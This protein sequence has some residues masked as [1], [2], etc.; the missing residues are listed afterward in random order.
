MATASRSSQP[1]RSSA[2]T[3]VPPPDWSFRGWRT[4]LPGCA[5]PSRVTVARGTDITCSAGFFLKWRP[6]RRVRDLA[7]DGDRKTT[8]FGFVPSADVGGAARSVAQERTLSAKSGGGPTAHRGSHLA[9]ARGSSMR[10][11]RTEALIVSLRPRPKLVA[12][13]PARW[14]LTLANAGGGPADLPQLAAGRRSRSSGPASRA[15][16]GATGECSCR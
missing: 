16:A 4:N 10:R 3:L 1:G 13:G 8:R 2:S 15:T 11:V 6:Y 14:E 9:A 5:D 12:R 7:I